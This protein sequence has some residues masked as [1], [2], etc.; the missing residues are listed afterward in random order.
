MI[1]TDNL[2]K[3][4]L[5]LLN[6]EKDKLRESIKEVIACQYI[7]MYAWDYLNLYTNLWN[8]TLLNCPN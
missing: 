2:D 3:T 8:V 1:K 5:N 7:Q 6:T 4:V